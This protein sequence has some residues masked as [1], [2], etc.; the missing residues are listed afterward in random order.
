VRLRAAELS[1]Q[2]ET[3][4]HRQH[5][6]VPLEA[7]AADDVEHDVGAAPAC[8]LLRGRHEV[9]LTVVERTLCAQSFARCAL[10][11]CW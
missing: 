9:D 8:G 2:D 11:R 4:F 5:V 7:V 3:P 1:D 10:L 6:D